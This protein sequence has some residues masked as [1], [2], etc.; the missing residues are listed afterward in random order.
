M[1]TDKEAE[2]DGNA[3]NLSA[4]WF[5][6]APSKPRRLV[7]AGARACQ[8][9]VETHKDSSD[10]A[11]VA[12]KTFWEAASAA[13]SHYFLPPTNLVNILSTNQLVTTIFNFF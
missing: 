12:I 11:P 8:D 5:S 9:C 7:L 13:N 3:S 1:Q 4:A 6:S 10:D 2:S